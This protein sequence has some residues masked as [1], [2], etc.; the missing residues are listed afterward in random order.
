MPLIVTGTVGIDTV[1]TPH[2]HREK[3][4]GG[5]C[6]YFAAAASFYTPVRIVAAV[7]EDFPN[8][9]R[10]T[11]G[12]FQGI[13]A[14]G[15]EVRR[16]SKTFAWGGKYH[17]NMNSRET[18]FTELGVLAE[19]PPE[20]P[21]GFKDSQFVFLANTHPGVQLMM[22][23]SLPKRRLVVADTMDLW[24]NIARTE[25]DLLLT[26][27]DGLVLNYDEA[28]LLT[29]K[30]N[31]V[32]AARHVLRMGPKFVVVKKGEHGCILVHRDGIAAL[33]AY[34]T[35]EVVDPTGAGDSF[36]GGMMGHIAAAEGTQARRHTGT[37]G[38]ATSFQTLREAL[39]HGTVVAS[40]NI[41]SFSLER[42]A[43]LTRPELE[44]RYEEFVRM[45]RV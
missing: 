4:L 38:E 10:G 21:A 15:L 13:D 20:I 42:L 23:E 37:Q 24:I 17:E 29:G 26:K 33:P 27:I 36:A 31:T 9:F 2:G 39:A 18:L 40:F 11:L 5:S 12:R 25:L 35:E 7:G 44:R 6:T 41:E 8:E 14:S 30:A 22:L 28:E 32:A 19:R 1:Y 45:V 43:T 3:V 34:P 16:G